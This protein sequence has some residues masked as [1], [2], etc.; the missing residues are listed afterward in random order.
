MLPVLANNTTITNITNMNAALVPV[1]DP[2]TVLLLAVFSLVFTMLG[3]VRY[4]AIPATI[5]SVLSFITGV[6]YAGGF[7]YY[8]SSTNTLVLYQSQPIGLL[9]ITVGI[10]DA[11][12]AIYKFLTYPARRR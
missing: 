4:G 5:G 7:A 11:A 3:L 1:V 10:V 12:M 2:A 9:F 6:L 8:D